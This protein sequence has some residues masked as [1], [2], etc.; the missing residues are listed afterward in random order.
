MVRPGV[1][2]CWRRLWGLGVALA[3]CSNMPVGQGPIQFSPKVQAAYESYR[4]S[5]TPGAFVVSSQGATFYTYCAAMDCV[6]GATAKAFQMCRERDVGECY[7]YA[8]RG[9]VVWREDLPGPGKPGVS[10]EVQVQRAANARKVDCM[11]RVEGSLQPAQTADLASELAVKASRVPWTLCDR[12]V[13]GLAD[14]TVTAD[15]LAAAEAGEIAPGL[16]ARLSEQG[17]V[18]A[19]APAS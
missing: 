13:D 3:G 6:G 7:L 15:E 17:I 12:L 9:R 11:R 4:R 2:G 19:S 10:A 18:G 1:G 16:A 8:E 14:G 5:A